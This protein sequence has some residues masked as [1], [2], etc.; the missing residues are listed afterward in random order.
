[1]IDNKLHIVHEVVD[2]SEKAAALSE[3][4]SSHSKYRYLAE[5]T[6]LGY[7]DLRPYD[8][9]YLDGLPDNMSG[10]WVVLSAVHIFNEVIPYKM[11]VKLGSNEELLKRLTKTYNKDISSNKQARDIVISSDSESLFLPVVNFTKR[12]DFYFDHPHGLEVDPEEAYPSSLIPNQL[13]A[14][15]NVNISNAVVSTDQLF[16]SHTPDVNANKQESIWRLVQ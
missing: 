1:M 9:I 13:T 7:P 2:T 6:L 11:E 14:W 15:A 5:A 12:D 3:A 16:N 4:Q 8:P 10:V